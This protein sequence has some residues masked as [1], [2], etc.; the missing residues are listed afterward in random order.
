MKERKVNIRT[1]QTTGKARLRFYG[2][3]PD[4]IDGIV[5]ALEK[6]RKEYE[7]DFDSVALE[8]ICNEYLNTP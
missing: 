6:A 4:Q 3:A 1:N 7:T 8:A 2:I 5:L